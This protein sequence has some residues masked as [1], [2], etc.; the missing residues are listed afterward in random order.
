MMS[1]GLQLMVYGLAGV[2]TVLIV[3]FFVSKALVYL[4]PYR[5]KEE[6]QEL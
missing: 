1:L 4:F 5:A 2:F 6:K 3:F